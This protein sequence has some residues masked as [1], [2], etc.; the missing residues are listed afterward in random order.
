MALAGGYYAC[1]HTSLVLPLMY[2]GLATLSSLT[3][4]K[5][6]GN[7]NYFMEWEAALCLCAGVGYTCLRTHL[8]R[9]RALSTLLPAALALFVASGIHVRH[10]RPNLKPNFS[11]CRQAYEF[12]RD[13][14]TGPILSE[15]VGAGILA[16]RV[17]VVLDPF[18]WTRGVL[19]L[20]IPDGE[21][22]NMIRSHKIAL[23]ILASD[24]ESLKKEPENPRWPSSVLYAIQ[25][26][27]TPTREFNCLDARYVYQPAV[28]R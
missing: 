25:E 13:Y 14:T 19:T 27:Y 6:G 8:D 5:L 4:G 16:G 28:P 23:I 18:I 11:G 12:V 7:F 24:T 15:N 22:I 26:T 17:P 1:P 20:G 10:I 9:R 21:V 3:V 2:L